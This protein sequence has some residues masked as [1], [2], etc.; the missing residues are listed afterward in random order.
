MA[1]EVFCR[2]AVHEVGDF[3]DAVARVRPDAVIVDVN[4]WGALSAA[5]AGDIPWLCFAPYTPFLKSHGV[6]PFGPGLKPMPGVLGRI[7]DAALRPLVMGMLEKGMLPPLNKIRADVGASRVASADEFVR[8]APLMLVA[9]GKPFEYPQTDWGDAVQMIGH[10]CLMTS[11]R[12][13]RT[14]WPRS[15]GRSCWSPRHRN[16]RPTRNLP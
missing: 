6:P 10:A 7:R 9:S 2:R 4:C 11:R 13:S 12:R 3:T 14:G 16:D 8:R 1:I 5:D 15:I